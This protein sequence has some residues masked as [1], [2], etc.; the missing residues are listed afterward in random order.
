MR[1][2]RFPAV[3]VA[4]L[5][6][7]AT[8]GG[9]LVAD[10]GAAGQDAGKASPDAAARESM[11]MWKVVTTGV[12]T[13][14]RGISVVHP[15]AHVGNEIV[16]ACGSNGVILKSEDSGK[17]WQQIKVPG[18][19]ELDFRG[20][21]AFS[22]AT[23]YLMSSGEG[24]KSRIY[25][26]TDGGATW[27]LQFTDTRPAFFL[28]A[29]A[30]DGELKCVALGDPVDGKFV[31]V[32]TTDGENWQLAPNEFMPPARKDEGAFAASNSSLMMLHAGQAVDHTLLYF[33]TGGPSGARVFRSPDF[34]KVWTA[35]DTPLAGGNA[36]SGI[37]SIARWNGELI[38]VGGDYKKPN[39]T[40]HTAA[41][42]TDHTKLY[43]LAQTPPS[44]FRSAVASL[45][46]QMLVTV[47]SNG[48]DFSEDGGRTWKRTDL[49]GLNAVEANYRGR[50]A[51]AWA[52]GSNGTVERLVHG[53][54]SGGVN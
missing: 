30:C 11:K 53:K 48:S 52:V 33:A 8:V 10:R 24:D 28:D 50:G 43:E 31:I 34:G 47:G 38:I 40:E 51:D 3:I 35:T 23:A 19:E 6:A 27:K 15:P 42:S 46:G 4:A 44:G 45:G 49:I 25:K 20:I 32:R 29:I 54:W 5:V 36:S 14:L 7:S 21:R 41:Y 17:T 22:T 9:R 12:D 39:D 2:L 37:F 1:R 26:T 13:N 16:W 18:G